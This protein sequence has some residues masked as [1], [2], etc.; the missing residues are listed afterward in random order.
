MNAY[1]SKNM[2]V[3]I[4]FKYIWNI[5]YYIV[6]IYKIIIFFTVYSYFRCTPIMF[7]KKSA[8]DG[9]KEKRKTTRATFGVK[10]EIISEHEN[11]VRVSDLA[12]MYC[13]QKFCFGSVLKLQTKTN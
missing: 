7:P 5:V 1:F 13:T 10:K 11:G 8:C 9:D 12:S 6:Y 3:F 2:V 4:L